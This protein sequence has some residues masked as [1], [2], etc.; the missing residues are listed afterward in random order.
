MK[1]K[2]EEQ[3]FLIIS[4]FIYQDIEKK[5][6]RVALFMYDEHTWNQLIYVKS[7]LSLTKLAVSIC[8]SSLCIRFHLKASCWADSCIAGH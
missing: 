1:V 2:G 8:Q 3:S 4:S 6:P 7:K 5:N